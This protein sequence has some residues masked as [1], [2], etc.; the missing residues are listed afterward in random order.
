MLTFLFLAYKH[1]I[2]R[3]VYKLKNNNKWKGVYL[4]DNLT[5]LE[6]EKKKDTRAIYT[7]T[8]SKGVEIR[9][10]GSNLVIDGEQTMRSH[11]NSQ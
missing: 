11:I 1:E 8:K 7:Y 3:N 10:K 6:Q 4:Q 5:R 2:Y 9:M